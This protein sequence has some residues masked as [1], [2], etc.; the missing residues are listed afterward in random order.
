MTTLEQSSQA[1]RARTWFAAFIGE[2]GL[3]GGELADN[4]S[5]VSFAEL[6]RRFVLP[7]IPPWA[8]S[9]V[10]ERGTRLRTLQNIRDK[11]FSPTSAAVRIE[12]RLAPKDWPER[13]RAEREGHL[14]I[15]LPVDLIAATRASCPGAAA[16]YERPF[17]NLW[18]RTEFQADWLRDYMNG[19]LANLGL[20]RT[21][22]VQSAFL[23]AEGRRPP[24]GIPSDVLKRPYA[25]RQEPWKYARRQEPWKYARGKEP[26]MKARADHFDLLVGFVAEATFFGD[27]WQLSKAVERLMNYLDLAD[28][29]SLPGIPTGALRTHIEAWVAACEAHI[30]SRFGPLSRERWCKPIL[31]S[32]FEALQTAGL[33]GV[34]NASTK[35]EAILSSSALQPSR[36]KRRDDNGEET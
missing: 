6:H 34:D 7:Q 22:E 25:R 14:F 35:G 24:K 33:V 18:W 3:D 15:Q 5:D 12:T 4:S 8:R 17:W 30:A 32:D 9:V 10:H 21:H 26:W 23:P 1:L 28:R 13:T 19:V 16:W 29:I 11:G 20:M 36:T 31:I 2:F 27:S